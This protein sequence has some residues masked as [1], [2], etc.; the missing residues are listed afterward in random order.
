MNRTLQKKE[1]T[2]N[3]E[4]ENIGHICQAYEPQEIIK[5]LLF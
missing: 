3:A 4:R 5:V 2:G 1:K